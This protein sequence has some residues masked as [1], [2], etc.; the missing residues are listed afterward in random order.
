MQFRDFHVGIQGEQYDVSPRT[1]NARIQTS[2][3]FARFW[4][5]P[6]SQSQSSRAT[7]AATITVTSTG[8]AIALDGFVTRAR[9]RSHRSTRPPASG[10]RRACGR[11]GQLILALIFNIAATGVTGH[12]PAPISSHH[13]EAGDHQRLQPAGSSPNPMARGGAPTRAADRVEYGRWA[14]ALTLGGGNSTVPERSS[15]VRTKMAESTG[16]QWG[17]TITDNSS[18]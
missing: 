3:L 11:V 12:R 7:L 8:D 17:N 2:Q 4:P 10:G 1:A 13:H 16:R 14:R 6:I 15:T 5:L 18:G 9:R